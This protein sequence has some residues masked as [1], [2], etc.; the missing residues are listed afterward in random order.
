V[1]ALR[2]Y[3]EREDIHHELMGLYISQGHIDKAGE[4]YETLTSI[5]KRGLNITPSKVT[6]QFYKGVVGGD[7]V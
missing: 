1:R 6:Q 4:Q 3:P 5:L 7:P 2:E